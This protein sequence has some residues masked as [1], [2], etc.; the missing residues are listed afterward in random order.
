MF[1]DFVLA[2]VASYIYDTDILIHAE[3]ITIGDLRIFT[4]KVDILGAGSFGMVFKGQYCE[5]ACAAKMVSPLHLEVLTG[6]AITQPEEMLQKFNRECKFIR[7]CQH[8]NIVAYYDTLF[9]PQCNLPVLVMELMQASL[10]RY[11]C[12]LYTSPSPRD[13]LLS[14]MP[15]SA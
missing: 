3:T 9:D 12:L 15:S 8:P 13:G 5:K 11:I 14:R 10:S 1:L 4:R 2:W 7:D 6:T